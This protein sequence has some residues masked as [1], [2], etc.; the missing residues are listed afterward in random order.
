MLKLFWISFTCVLPRLSE[1][2]I[3]IPS[4]LFSFY[5]FLT[6]EHESNSFQIA[7]VKETHLPSSNW[8]KLKTT[9]LILVDTISH[10]PNKINS[11]IEKTTTTTTL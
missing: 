6:T 10:Q 8:T 3:Y 11:S 2:N 9:N 7:K 5:M 4:E 1:R